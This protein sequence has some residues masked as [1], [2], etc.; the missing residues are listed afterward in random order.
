MYFF[1][2]INIVNGEYLLLNKLKRIL[3]I[4]NNKYSR[5][6]KELKNLKFDF[7]IKIVI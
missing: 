5:L 6:K 4:N 7:S 3:L 1:F 2:Y